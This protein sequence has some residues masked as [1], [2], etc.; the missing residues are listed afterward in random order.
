MD[1]VFVLPDDPVSVSGGNLYN[2]FLL[3]ALA[4][5]GIAPQALNVPEAC[6]RL[7]RGSAGIYLVDSVLHARVP[8]LAARTAAGQKLLMVVHLLPSLDPTQPPQAAATE[9]ERLKG[10]AG[11]VVTSDFAKSAVARRHDGRRPVFVVPPALVVV[12][13]GRSLP[14]DNFRGLL[15]GNVIEVKGVL[16][17]LRSLDS[18]LSED[19][20][21]AIEILGR[22]DF[23][24]DYADACRRLVA[25]SPRLRD[26]VR[27]AGPFAP[28][29]MPGIYERSNVF[30]SSSSVETYGMALHE[31]R[32]FGQF[33]LALDA[34]NVR[35]HVPS[36]RDGRLY[37]TVADLAHACVALIRDT[38]AL[39]RLVRRAFEHRRIERYTWDDAA[40]R[41][42]RQ[43]ASLRA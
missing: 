30:I 3:E 11:F 42:L 40:E 26:K 39:R 19:D 6:L 37:V 4:R 43:L 12:P 33:V 9:Q 36:D 38:P 15:V 20:A 16:A 2:R 34:G 5:K 18:L 14:L 31:A 27:F 32:A 22:R 8:D 1:L 28:E 7:D 41:L 25:D 10:I 23:E 29:A 13:T 35:A 17:F 21:F 24:P